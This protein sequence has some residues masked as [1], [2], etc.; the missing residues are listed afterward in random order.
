MP[1]HHTVDGVPITPGLRV[2][3]TDCAWGTVLPEQWSRTGS[4]NPDDDTFNGWFRVS[5]PGG[6]AYRLY[7]GER[8]STRNL[9][10]RP[11]QTTATRPNRVQ[12]TTY[13]FTVLHLA[14]SKPVDMGVALIEAD[15][16]DAVGLVTDEQ[17][18]EVNDADLAD[19]LKELGN[20]GTFFDVALGRE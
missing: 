11:E 14:D 12:A 18:V 20:D 1:Q 8:L 6:N 15:H 19:R 10:G 13:T 17:T 2:F 5:L 7:N 9:D 4:V 3:T 16:G